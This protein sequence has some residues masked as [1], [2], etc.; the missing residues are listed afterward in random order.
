MYVCGI[1]VVG[2]LLVD[3]CE[4]GFIV[5]EVI[6]YGIVLVDVLSEEVIVVIIFGLLV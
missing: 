1:Y 5:C 2:N 6:G 4:V 3:L